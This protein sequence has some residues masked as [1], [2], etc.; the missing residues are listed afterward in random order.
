M[1]VQIVRG[2]S[3]A[4]VYAQGTTNSSRGPTLSYTERLEGKVR[5]LQT[6]LQQATTN[7]NAGGRLLSNDGG[8]GDGEGDD[9]ISSNDRAASRSWLT[10]DKAGRISLCGPTSIFNT[11]F[12]SRS[13]DSANT[14][15]TYATD[16][17]HAERRREQL[18][19]NAWVLPNAEALKSPFHALLH[20]LLDFHWTWIQ[21]IFNFVYRPAFTRMQV[22][23]VY[24]AV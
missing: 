24:P 15:P 12:V 16:P 17:K 20:Y 9:G 2:R 3:V 6:L 7:S 5:E 21:P 23:H 19:T 10:T 4:G 22:K 18:V 13:S 14:P 8:D 1:R 11:P